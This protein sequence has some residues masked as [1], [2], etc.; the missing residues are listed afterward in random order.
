MQ[1]GASRDHLIYDMAVESCTLAVCPIKA[2]LNFLSQSQIAC[3][4]NPYMKG[5]HMSFSLKNK[6]PDHR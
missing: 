2:R 1:L 3:M 5:F 6:L 4:L